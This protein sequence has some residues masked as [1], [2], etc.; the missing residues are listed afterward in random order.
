[1]CFLS[2][3]QS[4]AVEET[5]NLPPSPPP[6]P[7]S[8]QT[9]TLEEAYGPDAS[10]AGHTHTWFSKGEKSHATSHETAVTTHV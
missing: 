7:A 3:V 5:A 4:L 8:E 1:M 10:C 2:I 9:G 6:S